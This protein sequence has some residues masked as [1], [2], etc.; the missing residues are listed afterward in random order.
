ME[1]L[2]RISLMIEFVRERRPVDACGRDEAFPQTE[3]LHW[4]HSPAANTTFTRSWCLT[5]ISINAWPLNIS[6]S[7]FLSALRSLVVLEF[8]HCDPNTLWGGI[9]QQAAEMLDCVLVT[10]VQVIFCGQI[11][12]R[13]EPWSKDLGRNRTAHFV[14]QKTSTRDMNEI[15]G[16]DDDCKRKSY[17]VLLWIHNALISLF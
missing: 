8:E 1:L 2:R 10:W 3:D 15:N 7:T 16:Q 12:V 14:R 5:H 17:R 4:T 13:I 6:F 11:E 9:K